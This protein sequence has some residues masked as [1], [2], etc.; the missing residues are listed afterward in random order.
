MPR[1]PEVGSSVSL[2]R[3]KVFE[4]QCRGRAGQGLGRARRVSAGQALSRTGT[5]QRRAAQHGRAWA[6][7]GIAGQRKGQGWTGQGRLG[8][9]GQG[10]FY[11]APGGES[12]YNTFHGPMGPGLRT[13]AISRKQFVPGGSPTLLY[14]DLLLDSILLYSLCSALLCPSCFRR[15]ACLI[16]DVAL[17]ILFVVCSSPEHAHI[18]TS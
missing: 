5:G 7:Q 10:L 11:T 17:E 8:R 12:M 15:E 9:A 16:V 3:K 4:G 18:Y 14:S 13:Q 2:V 6:G 1:G